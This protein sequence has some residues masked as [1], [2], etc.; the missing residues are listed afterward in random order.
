MCAIKQ[1]HLLKLY[2]GIKFEKGRFKVLFLLLIIKVFPP[3]SGK[4]FRTI[5]Q[6]T[7]IPVVTFDLP[8]TSAA[9]RLSEA[10]S[11]DAAPSNGCDGATDFTGRNEA[12]TFARFKVG[13]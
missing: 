4:L 13:M 12:V 6:V 11:G 1:T 5:F 9:F 10:R 8:E 7:G 2:S 3:V